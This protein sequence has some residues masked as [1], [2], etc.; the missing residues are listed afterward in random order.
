MELEFS[1]QIFDKTIIKDCLKIRPVCAEIQVDARTNGRTNMTKLIVIFRN[2][3]NALNNREQPCN[4]H[5][6]F[7]VVEF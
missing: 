2:F 7:N 3:A 6:G 4:S 1:Q 5:R